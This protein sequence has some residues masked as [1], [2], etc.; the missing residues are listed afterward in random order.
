MRVAIAGVAG[1]V[2]SHLAHALISRG[3]QVIGLDNFVSGQV[4]NIAEML[5]HE[6]FTFTEVDVTSPGAFE[7][8]G[9]VDVICHL[10]S[11]SSPKDFETKPVEILRASSI[12]TLAAV[13]AARDHSARLVF[14]S[15]SEVYGEPQVHPQ[16]ESYNG[17]VTTTGPRACYDESKRFGEAVVSTYARSL[18]LDGCIVRL[19]N[20]YGPGLRIDDGRVVSNFVVNALLGEPITVYGSGTQTRSFCYVDDLVAGLVA[21]I[22]SHHLGPINLGNPVESTVLELVD[23]VLELTDSRSAVIHLPLPQDDPTQRCP[24]ISLAR[25]LLRFEP[26]VSLSDGLAQT[27]DYFRQVIDESMDPLATIRQTVGKQ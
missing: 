9:A 13:E 7:R 6:S 25:T 16:P 4:S 17:N 3:D 22:D 20:T 14:T 5:E 1:L 21:V 15:T 18:G 2:G 24:D 10:A 11:P 19:F 23:L 12:G 27:V 8:L 26:V